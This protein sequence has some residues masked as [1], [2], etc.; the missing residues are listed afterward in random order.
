MFK[1][2][3]GHRIDSYFPYMALYDCSAGSIHCFKTVLKGVLFCSPKEKQAGLS[4]VTS[5]FYLSN[6]ETRHLSCFSL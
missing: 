6:G 2:I 4:W 3:Q 1:H 5:F